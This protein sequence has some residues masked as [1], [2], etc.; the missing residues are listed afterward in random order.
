MLI[1]NVLPF[2]YCFLGVTVKDSEKLILN[3]LLNIV[4]N[5]IMC[6]AEYR[7]FDSSP[8]PLSPFFPKHAYFV[9]L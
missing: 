5:N 7:L 1:I 4:V 2:K 8:S 3:N 9:A 6:K